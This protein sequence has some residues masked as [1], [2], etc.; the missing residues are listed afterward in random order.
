MKQEAFSIMLPIDA[1]ITS[2]LIPSLAPIDVL[3]LALCDR[4]TAELARPALEVYQTRAH[5]IRTS[6]GCPSIRSWMGGIRC[7]VQSASLPWRAKYMDAM[8]YIDVV[9]GSKGEWGVD[10]HGRGFVCLRTR[11][12]VV[13]LFQRFAHV[14]DTWTVSNRL[15]SFRRYVI[16]NGVVHYAL[17]KLMHRR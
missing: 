12:G 1:L 15:F 17:A 13:T 5:Q 14:P 16:A 8:G 4:R 7:M 11:R 6:I 2:V 10:P 9:D 3:A